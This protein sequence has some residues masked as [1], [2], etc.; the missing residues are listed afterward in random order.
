MIEM[1]IPLALSLA[2]ML[3]RKAIATKI[4]DNTEPATIIIKPVAKSAKIIIGMPVLM[5]NAPT[6][7]RERPTKR[8]VQ[9]TFLLTG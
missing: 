5:I 4:T 2:M 3:L 9:I 7:L 8:A 1:P 6:I